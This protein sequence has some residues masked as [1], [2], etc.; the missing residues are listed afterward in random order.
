MMQRGT[1]TYI[2]NRNGVPYRASGYVC[3]HGVIAAEC[4]EDP[5]CAPVGESMLLWWNSRPEQFRA[6]E[7]VRTRLI[8]EQ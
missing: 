2:V 4:T 7:V 1:F 8:N 5:I 6:R 3:Q